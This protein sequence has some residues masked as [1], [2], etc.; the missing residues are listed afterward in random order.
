M[1]WSK[2]LSRIKGM[3]GMTFKTTKEARD[4]GFRSGLEVAVARQL[5][6]AGV[7]YTYEEDVLEYTQ[8]A[9]Q[10]KYTPDF[11]LGSMYIETKGRFDTA[12]RQKMLL[13]KK[14][15]PDL[16]I[17]IVFSNSKAR[18][19]KDSKTTYAMWCE[20]HGFKYADKKIPAAWLAEAMEN[21]E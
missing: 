3:V 8:P 16:D 20:K 10:R 19:S 13:I 11:W 14:Q 6:D 18:I 15:H 9:K 1:S 5:E 12:D 4:L 21:E 17:R 2:R 7:Y